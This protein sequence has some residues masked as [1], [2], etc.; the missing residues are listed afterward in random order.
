VVEERPVDV[1]VTEPGQLVSYRLGPRRAAEFASH[2][3]D[4]IG[5]VMRPYRPIVIFL[6]A[7]A[8]GESGSAS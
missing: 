7:T 3:A 6:A 5:P 8:P 1:G 2:A 4:V